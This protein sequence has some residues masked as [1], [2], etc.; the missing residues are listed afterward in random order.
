MKRLILG[1][2]FAILVAIFA[3]QN[4]RPF[5]IRFLFW[6]FP[7]ISEALVI[8]A[9]VLLGVI[10]GAI[11]AWRERLRRQNQSAGTVTPTSH[12]PESIHDPH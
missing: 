7:R 10:L 12:G 6:Q 2:V 11:L 5:A 3:L 9:S 1:L 8:I 4:N